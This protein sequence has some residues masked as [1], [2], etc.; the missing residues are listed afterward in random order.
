[1]GNI[2]FHHRKNRFLF[3][4]IG[5]NFPNSEKRIFPNFSYSINLSLLTLR[6]FNL[7]FSNGISTFIF[8]YENS[9]IRLYK[10]TVHLVR[11]VSGRTE[12]N[13]KVWTHLPIMD[14]LIMAVY[15]SKIFFFQ[16]C[17]LIRVEH[18]KCS[19]M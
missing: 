8:V 3:F 2:R 11:G 19:E 15:G 18:K 14:P 12:K 16:S 17:Y 4:T 13:L 7:L 1:M 6:P 5:K 10:N 9:V